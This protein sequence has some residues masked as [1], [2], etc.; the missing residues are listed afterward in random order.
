MI[1]LL[2]L[3]TG[4]LEKLEVYRIDCTLVLIYKRLDPHG[5]LN[6]FQMYVPKSICAVD[7]RRYHLRVRFIALL[8]VEA[9]T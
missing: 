6:K 4:A 9:A 5:L 2:F 3:T 1:L 7:G 8:A